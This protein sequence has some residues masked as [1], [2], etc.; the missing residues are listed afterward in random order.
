M[1]L[2]PGALNLAW[3]QRLVAGFV[4]AGVGD[5]VISPGSRS[6]PLALALLRA[7]G[8]RVRVVVDERAAAFFAL[9]LAKAGG[10]PVVVVATSGSAP[11]N[12]FPAV[13]EA[14]QGRVPL[15]LIAADR[16][17]ELQACGANQTID[18]TRLFGSH[19]RASHALGV[20]EA[21]FDP[22]WLHRLAAQVVE[23]SGWPLAG[24]VFLNQPLR[25][26][27][28]P[29]IDPP[30]PAALPP[31]AIDHGTTL[32]SPSTVAAL[33]A[34]LS[35]RPGAIVCGE[36]P[37]TPEF[38][39][40]LAALAERLDCPV[41]AEPLSGVRFGPHDRSRLLVRYEGWL[42]NS[43][44]TGR[45]RPAWVLR[46]GAFPVTRTLQAFAGS[47]ESCIAVD[48]AP[49]WRDPPHR[50]DRLLRADPAA[51]CAT[52]A[53][54]PLVAA[55]PSWRQA[56]AAADEAA[57]ALL[58]SP[59]AGEAALLPALL[60][61][62]PEAC[63]LFVGN[64]M[65]VRDLDAFGGSGPQTRRCFG[66][67]G[68]SGIDGNLST[69]LGIAA[70]AGRVVALVGDLTCQH[71][72]GGLAAARGLDAVIVV[73]NNGGGGI[74]EYLPQ[75]GLAEFERGWLTPQDIDFAAAAK[76]FGLGYG[77][78]TTPAAVA[79]AVGA[80][81]AAGGPTLLEVPIDRQAS[82]AQRQSWLAAIKAASIPAP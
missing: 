59:A 66:N 50:V 15:I 12:W 75:A 10:R 56:F 45:H 33:A 24:P 70:A 65:L 54:Q 78:P 48:P 4:A 53:A 2:D 51:L 9:G 63:P 7:P 3:C 32:P 35:R 16:P 77:R 57:Q 26:P 8:L 41:L 47:G 43:A 14:S 80:A 22:A 6:T 31:V 58:P 44:F 5:A 21:G 19:V 39:P 38:A 64:S 13:V 76:T 71:D 73:C 82:V 42:H 27:L 69:A 67:R 72:L 68:V 11:A 40:A 61:A 52:L 34:T 36:M 55:A 23:E 1:S 37:P 81:L 18:Q 20:P 60:A 25:E 28:L 17:P 49:G 30:A 29:A 46:F 79:A 62:L 74:F